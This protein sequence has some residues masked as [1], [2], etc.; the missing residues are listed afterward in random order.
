MVALDGDGRPSFHILQN[1]GES[2]APLV[3]HVFDLLILVGRNVMD[4]TLTERRD[5]LKR[6]VLP[7]LKDPIRYSPELTEQVRGRLIL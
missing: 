6:K 2:P 3:F 7:K 5:L 4:R 1:H